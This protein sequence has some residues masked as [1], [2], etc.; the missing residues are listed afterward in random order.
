MSYG[1]AGTGSLRRSIR[2]EVAREYPPIKL[3][4]QIRTP[5]EME[6]AEA[7]KFFYGNPSLP[8]IKPGHIVVALVLYRL[9]Q[10]RG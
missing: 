10:T 5:Y 6:K 4:R 8:H 7:G 3:Y 1:N 9:Y 2:A